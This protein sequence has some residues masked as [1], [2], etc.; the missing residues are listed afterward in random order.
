MASSKKFRFFDFI[1]Q[2]VALFL[3]FL[4]TGMQIFFWLSLQFSSFNVYASGNDGELYHRYAV[5]LINHASN[6]WP[7]ILR[8]LHNLG[9]YHRS[10]IS[11]LMFLTT[12]TIIPALAL[13]IIRTECPSS[14]RGAISV[15]KVRIYILLFIVAYPSTFIFSLDIYRDIMMLNV[16]LLCLFTVQKFLTQKGI[17]R[18]L[19]LFIFFY[20]SYVALGLRV[21]LGAAIIGSFMC[22][23]FLNWA[24]VSGKRLLFG[25]IMALVLAHQMGWLDLLILYRGEDGFETGSTTFGIGLV[26]VN[27]VNFIMLV[28]LSLLY[29]VAGFYITGP[30][31]LFIFLAESLPVLGMIRHILRYAKFISPFGY[32]LLTFLIVY[33]FVWVI[34]NDNMGTA[35]RLRIPT[36]IG[37]VI[38]FG[39]VEIRRIEAGFRTSSR[40]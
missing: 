15:K 31:L 38:L 33:T 34:G 4:L 14:L 25:V 16:L 1:P 11:F 26:G 6:L 10:T 40:S 27:T 21:Y 12:L 29:Q 18:Y 30:I 17:K 20:L 5:G 35:M 39:C 2:K 28:C 36:Y 23:A 22:F 8:F 37:I 3:V 7:K 9:L 24:Q 13:A 32:Y 19:F